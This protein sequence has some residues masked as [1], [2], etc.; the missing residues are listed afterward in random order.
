MGGG[1]G[2]CKGKRKS[3]ARFL[4]EIALSQRFMDSKV[5]EHSGESDRPPDPDTFEK[6][7]DTPPISIA[8][9]SLAE[10]SIYTTKL[11]HDTAPICI[12]ILLQKY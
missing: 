7:R 10:S 1:G 12:A 2:V 3:L 11:Y 8:P 6:Y 4:K 9:S 5:V